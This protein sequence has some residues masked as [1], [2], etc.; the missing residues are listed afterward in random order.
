M[1][2]KSRF[3][4]IT[5][6]I[7]A[8]L[9]LILIVAFSVISILMCNILKNE[10]LSQ[11]KTDNLKLI[12]VYSKMIDM[13]NL[14]GF[15]DM[16]DAE[17]NLAY[18]LFIDSNL[19]AA[20]HSDPSRIGITLSD[21][22]SIAAA[23][24]GQQYADYYTYSVTD[25]LVLD[26]LEPI[27]NENNILIGALNIGVSV[28][29]AT[30]NSI[31][32][33]S[34]SG[35]IISFVIA[36]LLTIVIISTMLFIST[37]RPL[38]M[39]TKEL[40]RMSAYDM[41]P[42]LF[43]SSKRKDEIGRAFSAMEL[44]R[45]NLSSLIHKIIDMSDN[46]VAASEELTASC[47]QNNANMLQITTAIT[48]IATGA[49][50]QATETS[51]G[52][53]E[54]TALGNLIAENRTSADQLYS[55]LSTVNTIKDEGVETLKQLVEW[56]KL[57]N[58]KTT[59]V[60]D[61]IATTNESAQLISQSSEKIQQIASQTN[62]LALNAAIEAAR[63]GD[64]GLGFA[65]VA[66]QIRTLSEQTDKFAKEIAEVIKKLTKEMEQTIEITTEMQDVVARQ[67]E[68]VV[69]THKK[70]DGLSDNINYLNQVFNKINDITNQM[71][72][73]K[74]NIISVMQS[75]SAVSEENA[76]SSEEITATIENENHTMEEITRASEELVHL[77]SGVQHEVYQFK[78]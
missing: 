55:A 77:A 51:Q 37:I 26:I 74:E 45:K 53:E 12:K 73:G 35:S 46:V 44:M 33:H 36:M 5:V 18:A 30:L 39:I 20:A 15:I 41:T 31:L 7:T 78:F 13:D 63:A 75:L 6:K 9:T 11:W 65:V 64:A 69:T 4:N 1:Q 29:Q 52:A 32:V 21:A 58:T 70:Y 3:T 28:D 22:G 10:V 16:I 62:M 68:S 24:N 8:T 47:T 49:T 2:S 42:S 48:E 76:A 19:T 34:L 50:S 27:Y 57:N 43:S 61:T 60:R 14:Q 54:V 71:N 59:L 25:S 56:T 23:K 17:N 38:T 66:E 72:T 67:S 40:E